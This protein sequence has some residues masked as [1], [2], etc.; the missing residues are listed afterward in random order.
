MGRREERKKEQTFRYLDAADYVEKYSKF[1]ETKQMIYRSGGAIAQE[2]VEISD[3]DND[4]V[5]S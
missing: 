1:G 2:S 4:V 3:V 5:Q